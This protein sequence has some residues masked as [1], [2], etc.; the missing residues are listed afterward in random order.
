MR[1]KSERTTVWFA[2]WAS[3]LVILF[4]IAFRSIQGDTWRYAQTYI[5]L[6]NLG[7]AEALAQA[8]GNWLF[9]ILNW[10]LGQISPNPVFLNVFV[11]FSCLYILNSS[12]KKLFS[13]TQT[14]ICILLYSAFP[15]WVF[16]VSSG[17]K[18]AL[19]MGLLMQSYIAFYH[20]KRSAWLWLGAAPLVHSGALLVYPFVITHLLTWRPSFGY[21][22]AI[23]FSLLLLSASI[24]LSMAGLTK[25]FMQ[26]LQAAVPLSDNYE[27]YF[28]DASSFNY[29]AGFRWDFTIFSILPLM[30]AF[31]L[32]RRGNRLSLMVSGWWLNL[33]ILL[34]TIYQLFSFAP[35]ADRFAGFGWN[36][37]PLILMVM[38]TDIQRP[39][40][41]KR[42]ILLYSVANLLILQFYTGNGLAVAF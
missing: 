3:M 18:Q 32:R 26:P 2:G 14:A 20:Q 38:V 33:Y 16:Y 23:V 36:L 17:M 42:V 1:D 10:A 37:V 31:W 40:A 27:I 35:F 11:A 7:L 30:V 41:L 28:Q 29:R 22:R 34:I 13:P 15:F 4:G 25:T 5:R 21:R 12:L 8:D 6:S 24:F 39:L 9:V 19:A